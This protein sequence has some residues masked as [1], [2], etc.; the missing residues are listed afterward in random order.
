MTP[1]DIHTLDAKIDTINDRL[2]RI[3][4]LMET[5]S[6]RCPYRV[7]IARAGNNITRLER[8]ERQLDNLRLK[9]AGWAGFAGVAA[10]I[11][12]EIVKTLLS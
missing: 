12:S 11:A 4:T 8:V 9:I 6:L 1:D 7:D 2:A 3:E 5:E 10:A